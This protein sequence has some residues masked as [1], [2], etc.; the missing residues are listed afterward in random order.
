MSKIFTCEHYSGLDKL[1]RITTIVSKFINNLKRRV[2]KENAKDEDLLDPELQ[3]TKVLWHKEVQKDIKSH[4]KFDEMKTSL[5]IFEDDQGVL[6]VGGRLDN[7]N[8][9]RETKFPVLKRNH[10][11][12]MS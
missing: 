4:P 7:G 2:R 11:A 6:R 1:F 3:Q 9:P 8:L 5:K 10:F 12:E